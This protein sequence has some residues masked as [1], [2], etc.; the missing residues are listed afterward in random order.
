MWCTWTSICSASL[1][2][3]NKA[4]RHLTCKSTAL[5][6]RQAAGFQA[7]DLHGMGFQ[8]RH[9]DWMNAAAK[10]ITIRAEKLFTFYIM[11]SIIH[12]ICTSRISKESR[13]SAVKP[14]SIWFCMFV[15]IGLW[16][17]QKYIEGSDPLL[18][19]ANKQERGRNFAY[20]WSPA[21]WTRIANDAAVYS[22]VFNI[23]D[24]CVFKGL[25]QSSEC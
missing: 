4:P 18:R 5:A 6:M 23:S 14:W 21:V 13:D 9:L 12:L 2:S 3:W 17:K 10:A 7:S 11:K 22:C 15:M 20:C 25:L 16:P 19:Q 8:L 1:K 24:L